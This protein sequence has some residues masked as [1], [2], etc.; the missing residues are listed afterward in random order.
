MKS[1]L[2][3]V[4]ALIVIFAVTN[5]ARAQWV[6]TNGPYNDTTN[7]ILV[8]GSE[9]FEGTPEGVY[10]STNEG[11]NWTAANSGLTNRNVLSLASSDSDLYAG[12]SNGIFLSTNEGGSW[13]PVDSGMNSQR[14]IYCLTTL[15]NTVVAGA[16]G[17]VYVSTDNG[18][19]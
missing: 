1:A 13:V 4:I 2:G 8:K 14:T 17:E 19:F 16:W 12:T 3:Y 9:I 10:L 11:A 18:A 6:Q 15:G 5:S 7:C